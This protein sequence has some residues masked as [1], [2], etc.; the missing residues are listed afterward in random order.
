M[1]AR[2]KNKM[3]K[4]REKSIDVVISM[5]RQ[6]YEYEV[7]FLFCILF[8]YKCRPVFVYANINGLRCSLEHVYQRHAVAQHNLLFTLDISSSLGQREH[9]ATATALD[10]NRNQRQEKINGFQRAEEYSF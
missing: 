7:F 2:E 4:R 5:D 3:R 9:R 1:D 6:T 8:P 10:H